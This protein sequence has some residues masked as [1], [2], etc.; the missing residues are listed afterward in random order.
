LSEQINEF[1]NH[2]LDLLASEKDQIA[3]DDADHAER[4]EAEVANL[5][6]MQKELSEAMQV[7]EGE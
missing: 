1:N 6:R 7:K 2:I 4:K 5:K 3:Q